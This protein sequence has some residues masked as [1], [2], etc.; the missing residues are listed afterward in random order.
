M[1]DG[2]SQGKQR[3]KL[4]EVEE[5]RDPAPRWVGRMLTSRTFPTMR[6]A[7]KLTGGI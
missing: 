7:K 4:A 1:L 6:L 2:A 3:V 5:N